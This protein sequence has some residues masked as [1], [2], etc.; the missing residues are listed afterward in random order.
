MDD[1]VDIEGFGKKS[2]E[3]LIENIKRSKDVPFSRFLYSLGINNIGE[4][5]SKDISRSFKSIEILRNAGAD[6]I[7]KIFGVG[8]KGGKE[9]ADWFED[10]KN[11]KI[12]DE[13]LKHINIIYDQTVPAGNQFEGMS[14]VL[15]GSLSSLSRDQAKEIIQ[16]RGGKVSGSVSKKTSYLVKGESPGSKLAEAEANQVKIIN[17]SDFLK[18]VKDL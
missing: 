8:D 5:T 18:L 1:I 9:A 14:F 15:T 11:Q 2:A 12:L 4:E 7:S 3:K 16:D 17:E 10:K 6:Q 13:L